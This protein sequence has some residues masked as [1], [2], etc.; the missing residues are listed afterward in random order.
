MR[1]VLVLLTY[2]CMSWMCTIGF[3][4][5]GV[6]GIMQHAAAVSVFGLYR[7]MVPPWLAAESL[8]L[9]LLWL[10]LSDNGR[11]Y[12]HGFCCTGQQQ[13][14]Y[15][16]MEKTAIWRNTLHLAGI[17]HGPRQHM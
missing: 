15:G 16:M 12:T 2:S 9:Y 13:Q 6:K 7:T 8:W 17:S 5:P 11:S 1:L 14:Q 10:C 3:S 4:E